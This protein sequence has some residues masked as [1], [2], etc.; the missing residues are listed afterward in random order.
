MLPRILHINDYPSHVG[1]GA[2]VVMQTSI[3]LLRAAGLCVDTFTSEDLPDPSRNPLRYIHNRQAQ[4]AL[5]AKLQAFRPD[6]VHLHNFYHVLS[7]AIL[8]TLAD[9]KKQQPLRVVMTAHDY[10]LLCP[11]SGGTW[12]R[13][14]TGR[15]EVLETGAETL[16]YQLTRRW[17]HRGRLHSLLRLAQHVWNY[18]IQRRQSVI[19]L[20]ICPSR[21]LQ[22]MLAPL[23]LP[24]CVLPH[25]APPAVR[26]SGVRPSSL[27]FIVA[28]RIEPEKGLNQLLH[29]WPIGY[30]A[31]LIVVGDGSELAACRETCARRRLADRV[32]FTGRL[33]HDETIARIAQC[34]LL[35]QPSQV[36]ETY[37]LTLLEA[38]ACGTNVLAVGRGAMRE[39]VQT[40]G[41][42]FLYTH[43]DANDLASRLDLI[44]LEFDQGRLN[45]FDVTPFLQERSEARYREQ[46][47]RLYGIENVNFLAA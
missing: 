31:K 1:G 21:F 14:W 28:G 37:A 10:H 15:R 29:A 3:A 23:N 2:E 9:Y 8:A 12:F 46:L 44:Q 26:V 42:G 13:A 7:P 43:D 24:A 38:L 34:H 35:V 25:P 30:D 6:V 16:T 33:S 19:D 32:E 45:R 17:D 27:Q 47:L 5:A 40:A 41:V 36:L 11:N 18:R 22:E 20:V 39:I 4:Q